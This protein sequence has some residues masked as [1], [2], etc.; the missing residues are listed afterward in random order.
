MTG[1]NGKVSMEEQIQQLQARGLFDDLDAQVMR[2]LYGLQGSE[3]LGERPGMQRH[4]VARDAVN[5][6]ERFVVSHAGGGLPTAE[7]QVRMQ[8]GRGARLGGDAACAALIE[9]MMGSSTIQ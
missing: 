8:Y 5:A 9:R 3:E 1:F 4:E 7:Q 6:L 2:Q